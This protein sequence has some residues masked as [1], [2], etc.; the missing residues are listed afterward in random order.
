MKR[1]DSAGVTS[2]VARAHVIGADPEKLLLSIERKCSD[3]CG[4]GREAMLLGQRKLEA[5]NLIMVSI[6][7]IV[8][9]INVQGVEKLLC[10]LQVHSTSEKLE[11][12]V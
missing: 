5:C 11:W 2:S 12:R 7:Q 4:S 8:F 6:P 1:S 9:F 3:A 10:L